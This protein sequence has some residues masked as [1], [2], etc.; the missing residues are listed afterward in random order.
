MTRDLSVATS[1]DCDHGEP[2]PFPECPP[3][4]YAL[5]D[6][7]DGK[8]IFVEIVGAQVRAWPNSAPRP[9]PNLRAKDYP[10][11]LGGRE[12]AE[13]GRRW[14]L[15]HRRPWKCAVLA[16]IAADPDIAAARFEQLQHL[17]PKPVRKHTAAPT[18]ER[19]RKRLQRR[20]RAVLAAL[21]VRAGASV[22]AVAREADVS[23]ATARAQ[24][25]E[26]E[27]ILAVDSERGRQVIVDYLSL[28]LDPAGA[29][30]LAARVL[31]GVQ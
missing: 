10:P 18:A 6:P 12:R 27:R 29:R 13:W 23:W 7:T 4:R 20:G 8:L 9:G 24:V 19:E 30:E 26:G 25:N 3:G 14:H 16:A 22:S 5:P 31:D 21:R 11:D 1:R 15:M 17:A 2:P 28:V